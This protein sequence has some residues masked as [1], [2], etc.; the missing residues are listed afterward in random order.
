ME[1]VETEFIGIDLLVGENRK[2]TSFPA[3]STMSL[4][5]KCAHETPSFVCTPDMRK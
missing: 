2:T 5:R 4:A 1:R 3:G